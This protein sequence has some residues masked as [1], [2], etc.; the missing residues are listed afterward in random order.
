MSTFK[1]KFSRKAIKYNNSGTRKSGLGWWLY[2]V[3]YQGGD[4]KRR[5]SRTK[6]SDTKGST[7]YYKTSR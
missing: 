5:V 2:N 3:S 1:R 6:G 4:R 7:K